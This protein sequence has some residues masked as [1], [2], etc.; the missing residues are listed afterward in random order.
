MIPG[1][2]GD[3][4]HSESSQSQLPKV[5]RLDCDARALRENILQNGLICSPPLKLARKDVS[6]YP[7]SESETSRRGG[8]CARG[9]GSLRSPLSSSSAPLLATRRVRDLRPMCV[10]NSLQQAFGLPRSCTGGGGEQQ[11]AGLGGAGERTE[12]GGEGQTEWAA[13]KR[14]GGS[15]GE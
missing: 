15:G 9:G 13:E 2:Q 4:I 7:E 5:D 1:K 6:E 14:G 10:I 8:P 3:N 11:A 12:V